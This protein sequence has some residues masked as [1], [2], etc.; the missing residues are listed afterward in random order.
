MNAEDGF[1]GGLKVAEAAKIAQLFADEGAAA[2]VPSFGYTSLNGFGMLRGNVPHARM[3]ETM[4]GVTWLIM[5]LFGKLLVPNIPFESAFLR[6]HAKS[7]SD[8]L[9]GT[10]CKVIYI[11][12]IDGAESLRVVFSECGCDGA[13][14]GRALIREPDFVQR[15]QKEN[16]NS[17][18]SKC[19]RCNLCT[20]ASL[21]PKLP[22]GCPFYRKEAKEMNEDIEDLG[23]PFSAKSRI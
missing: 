10:F 20:L 23:A 19:I 4:K 8:A 7:F 17:V 3:T 9:R 6:T 18:S 16:N 12:G 1:P 21:D 22:S 14:I 11:G 15:L 2:I 5:K 13:Q